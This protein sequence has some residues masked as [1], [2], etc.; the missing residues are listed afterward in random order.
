MK[1]LILS[2]A[3]AALTLSACSSG[4]ASNSSSQTKAATVAP[5]PMTGAQAQFVRP[6]GLGSDMQTAIV[7][8][9]CFWCVESDFEKLDGVSEVISGYSGGTLDDPTYEAVSYK[10]TGHYEAAMI[11]YDPS[12]VTY[13]Q[14]IDQ[15]W[16]T[17]DPTD[18]SGQ[19]CDKGSSYRT[20]IF[21]TPDQ[22]A[23]AEASKDM[24]VNS[25]KVARVV[26]PVLPATTFY[27][28]EDYHQDYYKKNPV[29]YKGY[30]FG[31]RRDARLAELWGN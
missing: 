17:V 12:I 24:I 1:H 31:C 22:R 10:E 7:A 29:R 28:A 3:M 5:A 16:M 25:G 4:A 20:A 6:S 27:P 2:A 14:L 18:S 26:T 21:T 23:E 13:R 8:G 11:I 30:R 15:Y 19:F 9:G